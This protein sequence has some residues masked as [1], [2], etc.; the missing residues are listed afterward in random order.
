MSGIENSLKTDKHNNNNTLL[1]LTSYVDTSFLVTNYVTDKT[2]GSSIGEIQDERHMFNIFGRENIKQHKS[3]GNARNRH[4]YTSV[5]LNQC[6]SKDIE[7]LTHFSVLRRIKHY[8][9]FRIQI[10]LGKVHTWGPP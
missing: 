4:E 3:D 7:R 8:L 2:G 1:L 6:F 9:K 5:T 10:R